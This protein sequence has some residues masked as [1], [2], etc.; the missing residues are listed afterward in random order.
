M[1]CIVG[2]GPEILRKFFQGELLFRAALKHTASAS[3]LDITK[4]N[5]LIDG[6]LYQHTN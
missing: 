6:I 1:C 5:T 3:R 4:V 2:T